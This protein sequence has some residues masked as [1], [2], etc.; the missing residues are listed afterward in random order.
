MKVFNIIFA[1]IIIFFVS[2]FIIYGT[3]SPCG[4]LKKEIA[5]QSGAEKEGKAMY[6]L[7]GGFIERGVDTL[8][9]TQCVMGVYKVKTGGVDK[10]MNE[11]LK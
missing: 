5:R 1:I 11:L 3:I 10:T 7:F 8:S 6:A 4:I 2:I 9:P